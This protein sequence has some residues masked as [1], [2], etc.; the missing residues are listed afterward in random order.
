MKMGCTFSFFLDVDYSSRSSRLPRSPY[1]SSLPPPSRTWPPQ[2]KDNW[3]E[4]MVVADGPMVAYH[5]RRLREYILSLMKIV[6]LIYR[7]KSLGNSVRMAV[8]KILI[9]DEDETFAPQKRHIRRKPTQRRNNNWSRDRDVDSSSMTGEGG[10]EAEERISASDMLKAFCKWQE[11]VSEYSPLDP[12]RYDVALLLTRENICRNLD[13]PSQ[14][15]DTLGLA[16]LGT[17][18][19]RH[20]CAIVQDN[21][22][23]AAFTIAHE[24]GHVL[25]MPHDDD[26]KCIDFAPEEKA[27]VSDVTVNNSVGSSS[28]SADDVSYV[29]SRMLDHNTNPWE[30]SKCS[31]HYVTAFLDANYGHCLENA[32]ARNY[33]DPHSLNG[34]ESGGGIVP[35]Y[36]GESFDE[37]R[38]CEFVFGKGSKICSYMVR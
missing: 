19:D 29:M 4:V 37:N 15:C 3:I 34:G 32:P 35:E 23:S 8:V 25:N 1:S 26:Q 18:C 17:M 33:L 38:Q 14:N 21:G 22:L 31:R 36:P 11:R 12:Q 2:S 20:S 30:W 6:S 10:G 28:S 7:D 9:L 27:S 13:S 16:E 24:L 5:G